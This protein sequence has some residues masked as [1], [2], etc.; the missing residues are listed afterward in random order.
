MEGNA[1]NSDELKV[2]NYVGATLA[3]N[4]G[5]SEDDIIVGNGLVL[6]TIESGVDIDNAEWYFPIPLTEEWLVKFG[7]ERKG[8]SYYK[9]ED[10][11]VFLSK[12]GHQASLN[13]HPLPSC[14]EYIHQLQN[15][16][17]DLFEEK[18]TFKEMEEK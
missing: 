1:M 2:G 12:S 16:Y 10:F 14:I 18:L 9:G 7:F 17:V 8:N 13:E 3:G 11:D 4:I 5:P 15:L 6:H